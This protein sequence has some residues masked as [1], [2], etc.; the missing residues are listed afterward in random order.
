MVRVGGVKPADRRRSA[1][2]WP[3]GTAILLAAGF[4]SLHAGSLADPLVG[5]DYFFIDK[6]R[7]AHGWDLLAPTNLISSFYRPWSRELHFAALH[8]IAGLDPVPYHVTNLL[9]A[10]LA[11]VLFHAYVRRLAGGTAAAIATAGAAAL[12]AWTL[13]VGWASCSQDL[14]MIVW[15]LLALHASSRGRWG[16]ATAAF[17]M[18]LLSKETAAMLPVVM[19]AEARLVARRSWRQVAPIA[20]AWLAVLALWGAFHPLLGG[21][22]GY[23][24]EV[25]VAMASR[26][27]LFTILPG[28]LGSVLQLSSWPAPETGW[29]SALLRAAPAAILLAGSIVLAARWAPAK[30]SEDLMASSRAVLPL[31]AVWAVSAWLPLAMPGVGWHAYYGTFGAMGAWLAL[32]CAL[33]T[34]PRLAA[35]LVAIVASLGAASAATPTDDWGSP[36]FQRRAARFIGETRTQLLR[37]HPTLD[38][39]SRLYFKGV[40]S[41]VGLVPGGEE[42]PVLRVWYDDPGLRVAFVSRYS[43]RERADTAGADYFFRHDAGQGWTEI[44]TASANPP[45]DTQARSRWIHDHEELAEMFVRSG[46]WSL[47]REEFAGLAQAAPDVAE[48]QL[49]LALSDC[50]LGERTASQAAFTRVLA[51]P[52]ADA[53]QRERA[54]RGCSER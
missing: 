21:R 29:A 13:F 5:D 16:W 26:P 54:R 12:S 38:P 39:G 49:D 32:G 34:R 9:L 50:A 44:R 22:L 37:L 48:Y 8:D 25:A 28:L 3:V 53:E 47:A 31:G 18:A 42:S 24:S 43:A 2:W 46:E 52:G 11:L 27:S 15:G 30:A 19:L 4:L 6:V 20:L 36:W 33:A 35:V 51:M 40:P 1:A 45:I 7:S 17:L 41:G 14:W 10:L 23:A